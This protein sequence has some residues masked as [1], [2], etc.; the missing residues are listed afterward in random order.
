MEQDFSIETILLK[1]KDKKEE[2]IDSILNVETQIKDF[3]ESRGGDWTVETEFLVELILDNN[4]DINEATIYG[5]SSSEKSIILK[6]EET[7][8]DYIF[9]TRNGLAMN[10]VWN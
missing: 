7:G 8:E 10:V 1:G 6:I 5:S 4:E 2:L 9:Y 3:M